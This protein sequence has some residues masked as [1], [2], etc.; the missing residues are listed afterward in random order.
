VYQI[1]QLP[2]KR[3]SNE[4]LRRRFGSRHPRQ[5]LNVRFFPFRERSPSASMNVLTGPAMRPRCQTTKRSHVAHG[6]VTGIS[7][8][9]ERRVS[10]AVRNGRVRFRFKWDLC[11][12]NGCCYADPCTVFSFVSAVIHLVSSRKSKKHRLLPALLR[13]ALTRSKSLSPELVQLSSRRP[14]FL[15]SWSAD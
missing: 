14:G 4:V 3:R 2:A 13:R 5:G 1:N 10:V 11:I 6:S 8:D 12:G 9:R 15:L 7:R